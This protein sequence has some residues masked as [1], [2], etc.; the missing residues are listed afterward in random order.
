MWKSIAAV[1]QDKKK[2]LLDRQSWL[3]TYITVSFYSVL[4]TWNITA[5]KFFSILKRFWGPGNRISKKGTMW[6]I[7][8]VFAIRNPG[9]PWYRVQGVLLAKY[10][11]V[12]IWKAL[13]NFRK[14]LLKSYS[15]AINLWNLLIYLESVEFPV[16]CRLPP[17]HSFSQDVDNDKTL[18]SPWL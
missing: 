17:G 9:F 13:C 16:L 4:G 15:S 18:E 2:T 7:M 1:I 8:G 12:H 10:I 3:Q 14:R 6:E 5:C 11:S